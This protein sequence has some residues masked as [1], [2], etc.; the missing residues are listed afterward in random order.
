MIEVKEPLYPLAHNAKHAK[1]LKVNLSDRVTPAEAASH[2]RKVNRML[3]IL[4]LTQLKI[5]GSRT[6]AIYAEH[7]QENP[8]C[9]KAVGLLFGEP[10][11]ILQNVYK[12]NNFAI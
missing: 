7:K 8:S 5:M 1:A 2:V 12:S 3:N 10:D 9:F 4:I 11:C 6:L